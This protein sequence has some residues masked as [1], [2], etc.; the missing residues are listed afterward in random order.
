MKQCGGWGETMERREKRSCRSRSV[1][2]NRKG[3]GAGRAYSVSF[4][5]IFRFGK[6]CR[7]PT[8]GS[9]HFSA[10]RGKGESGWKGKKKKAQSSI[11]EASGPREVLLES[12]LA[13]PCGSLSSGLKKDECRELKSDVWSRKKRLR[14]LSVVGVLV[15]LG[16]L[17]ESLRGQ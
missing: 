13:R 2:S 8:S 5:F 17:R 10:P 12:L 1:C 16:T 7:S 6:A 9:R 14:Y 4:S 11:E 3:E 15:F